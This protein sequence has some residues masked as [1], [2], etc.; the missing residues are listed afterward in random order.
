MEWQL[1]AGRFVGVTGPVVTIVMDGV[2]LGPLD[3]GNAVHL[4]RTPTLDS[5]WANYGCLPIA[6][7]GKAVGLPSDSTGT[8]RAQRHWRRS[9]GRTRGESGEYRHRDRAS[10]RRRHLGVDH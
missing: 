10:L 1:K 5:L 8:G 9:G 4:A 3:E 6:A 7:H 2:G